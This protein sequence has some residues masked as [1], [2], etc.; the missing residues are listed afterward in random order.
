[1]SKTQFNVSN[2]EYQQFKF[3]QHL[4]YLKNLKKL[5]KTVFDDKYACTEMCKKYSSQ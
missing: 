4:E 1:M 5:Q 3:V 2:F